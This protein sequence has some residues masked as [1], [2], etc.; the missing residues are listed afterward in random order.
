MAIAISL[1]A[2]QNASSSDTV[3]RRPENTIFRLTIADGLFDCFGLD[4]P[5]G[6]LDMGAGYQENDHMARPVVPWIFAVR[7]VYPMMELFITVAAIT[8]PA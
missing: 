6:C 3:V 7:Q 4:G 1:S 8:V 5:W 2:I